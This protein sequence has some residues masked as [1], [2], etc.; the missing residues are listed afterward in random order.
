MER[1]ASSMT[2]VLPER[3]NGVSERD[4]RTIFESA[5]S[6]LHSRGISMDLWAEAINCSVY[7]LNRVISRTL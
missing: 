1:G 4:N 3:Q 6:L 7:T 5:R 2:S